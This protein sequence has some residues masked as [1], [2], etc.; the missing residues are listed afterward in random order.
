MPLSRRAS[1]NVD[2]EIYTAT[3]SSPTSLAWSPPQLLTWVD[4]DGGAL[5]VDGFLSADGFSFAFSSD[6]QYGPG[7]QDLFFAALAGYMS[8]GT[9]VPM[10]SLN[11]SGFI[12]ADPWLSQDLHEIYFTSDRGGSAKIYHATR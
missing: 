11:A 2:Y 6:R 9:P 8:P 5:N 12:Q 3:R 10:A 1:S 7:S 4:S